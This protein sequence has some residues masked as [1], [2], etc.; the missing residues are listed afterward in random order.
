MSLYDPF[1][2]LEVFK[3]VNLGHNCRFAHDRNDLDSI[4]QSLPAFS[5]KKALEV[6]DHINGRCLT[7]GVTDR[8]EAIHA[9]FFNG[10]KHFLQVVSP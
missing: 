10:M 7:A 9:A 5:V 4:E 8:K 3:A 6:T 2:R 1:H